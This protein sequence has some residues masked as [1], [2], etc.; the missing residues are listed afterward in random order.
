MQLVSGA[1]FLNA[2]NL[3]LTSIKSLFASFVRVIA[4]LTAIYASLKLHKSD[5]N[6]DVLNRIC[7]LGLYLQHCQTD[8]EL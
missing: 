3:F 2:K 7:V 6:I 5:L 1:L 8:Q 4:P